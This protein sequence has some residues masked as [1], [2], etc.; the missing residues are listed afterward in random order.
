MNAYN[1]V[2][3]AA[4]EAVHGCHCSLLHDMTNAEIANICELIFVFFSVRVRRVSVFN[5]TLHYA[6]RAAFNTVK[7]NKYEKRDGKNANGILSTFGIDDDDGCDRR[8][9]TNRID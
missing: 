3:T 2:I 4:A 5:D 9:S 1:D 6:V 7:S 8:V